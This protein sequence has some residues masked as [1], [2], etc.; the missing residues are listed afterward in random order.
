MGE[1]VVG[2]VA[3]PQPW[4]RALQAHVRD[5]VA[6]VR[7]V[8]L[9]DVQDAFAS[10]VDVVVVDDTLDF[11]TPTQAL[12]LR[13]QGA[14]IVG[15][16]DPSGRH[17]RGIGPLEQLRVDAAIPV[18]DVPVGLLAELATVNLHGRRHDQINTPPAPFPVSPAQR[19][20]HGTMLAVA[21]GTD[22]PGRT[23]VAIALAAAIAAGGEPAVLV[24]VDEHNPS[25]AR[26]LGYQVAPNILDVLTGVETG[27]ELAVAQRAAF[28]QG[29][30]DFDV[31]CGL[32]TIDDWPQ[33]RDLGRLLTAVTLRW[34]H[35]VIDTGPSCQPDHIPPGGARNAATRAVLSAADQ[36]VAVCTPTPLGVLRLLDW[37]TAAAELIGE[38]PTTIAVNRAP[39][40]KF[41]QDQLREQLVTNL[42]GGFAGDIC[43][44][45]DDRRVR[46]A[47]WD[48]TV[49][50]RGRYAEEVN[51]LAGRLAPS[52]RALT[53]R[54]LLWTMR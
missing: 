52:Q 14:R 4:R 23:E 38:R 32:A 9:H 33:L 49:V 35:T 42:P 37:A 39:S 25:V 31:I 26:R 13:D 48:G 30:V 27:A 51:V 10:G 46:D 41:H 45:R 54:G 5:H 12:A 3:T 15:V 1:L 8:V 17:G 50:P 36:I 24:D 43:F 34:G 21:G 53:R 2:T 40:S 16:Y 44:L 28:A 29:E 20:G 22:S 19:N 6:G 11:L 47:A 7:L 18:V